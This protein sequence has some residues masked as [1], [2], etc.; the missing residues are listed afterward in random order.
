MFFSSYLNI[1]K[2]L[3]Q[4]TKLVTLLIEES[5]LPAVNIEDMAERALIIILAEFS[6]SPFQIGGPNLSEVIG[7][8]T[9]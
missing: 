8:M 5:I 2:S 4:I 7:C 9:Q 1:C 3:K 6:D